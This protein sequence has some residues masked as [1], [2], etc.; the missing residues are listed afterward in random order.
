MPVWP[1]EYQTRD[2]EANTQL[3]KEST[4]EPE[5]GL[6]PNLCLEDTSKITL[7]LSDLE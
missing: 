3:T 6:G 7:F 5:N 4:A 1:R 2:K